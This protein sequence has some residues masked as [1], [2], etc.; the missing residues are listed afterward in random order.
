MPNGKVLN[1]LRITTPDLTNSRRASDADGWVPNTR[2]SEA[3]ASAM[4]EAYESGL[5]ETSGVVESRL[6][7]SFCMR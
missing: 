2:R 6:I 3:Y 7:P 4:D 1:V 5:V